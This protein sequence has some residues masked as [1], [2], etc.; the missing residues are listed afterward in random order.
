MA[1][2]AA[3]CGFVP[4][5]EL[6]DLTG[7]SPGVVFALGGRSPGSAWYPGGHPGSEDVAIYYLSLVPEEQLRRTWLLVAEDSPTAI[8]PDRVLQ[9]Y[10]RPFPR[11]YELCGYRSWPLLG[12]HIQLWKPYGWDQ[13]WFDP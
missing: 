6:I 7:S 12:I 1:R 8:D 5:T 2:I 9:P 4:G 11:T 13:P 10:G 3:E